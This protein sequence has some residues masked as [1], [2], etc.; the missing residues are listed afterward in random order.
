VPDRSGQVRQIADLFAG[1]RAS[2][3]LGIIWYNQ[4]GRHTWRLGKSRRA[5]V[6][7]FRRGAASMLASR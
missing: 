6:A 2:D 7:A 5:A 4:N 3:L 1:A